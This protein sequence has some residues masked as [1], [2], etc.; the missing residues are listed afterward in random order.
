MLADVFVPGRVS[1]FGHIE[2]TNYTKTDIES[3]TKLLMYGNYVKAR[4]F[5]KN[6][7]I[8]EVVEDELA[9]Y[10]YTR[11]RRFK[12]IFQY[13]YHRRSLMVNMRHLG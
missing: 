7:T 9:H 1:E 13:F 10:P 8:S 4:Q 5:A 3:L 11:K 12:V 6:V 2:Y